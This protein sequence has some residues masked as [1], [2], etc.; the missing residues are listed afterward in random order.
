[1]EMARFGWKWQ[2][3]LLGKMRE[4]REELDPP[5]MRIWAGARFAVQVGSQFPNS[6]RLIVGRVANFSPEILST[7][8]LLSLSNPSFPTWLAASL[9]R[10][11]IKLGRKK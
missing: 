2:R 5:F 10:Q 7:R 9:D 3:G 4:S 8:T 1:M 6:H 11:T